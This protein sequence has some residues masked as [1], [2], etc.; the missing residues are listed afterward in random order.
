MLNILT[1]FRNVVFVLLFEF[2]SFIF[3][4]KFCLSNISIL[5]QITYYVSKIVFKCIDRWKERK[6]VNPHPL[7]KVIERELDLWQQSKACYNS[8]YKSIIFIQNVSCSRWN[9]IKKTE[10]VNS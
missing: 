10:G 1:G 4:Q 8:C 9:K 2:S 7:H 6:T 5:Q 3:C